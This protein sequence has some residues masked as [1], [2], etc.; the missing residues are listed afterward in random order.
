MNYS[1]KLKYFGAL[2][3]IALLTACASLSIPASGVTSDGK[4]WS[5]YFTLQEF[6]LS[7]GEVICKG[8]TPMGTAK[9]QKATF[10]CNDGRT[11]VVE[12]NRTSMSGGVAD[13]EF[14]DGLTGRFK[15][16]S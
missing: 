1:V 11:G 14:S 5:G 12:T 4:G 2:A 16:G 13:V 9:V 15:Y 8:A 10:S 7:D 6:T 3:M